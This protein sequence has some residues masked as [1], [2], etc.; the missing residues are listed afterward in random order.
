[1]SNN[2]QVRSDSHLSTQY[3]HSNF[4][5]T[6]S[7]VWIQTADLTD[8]GLNK[9]REYFFWSDDYSLRNGL[10]SL[11]EMDR[12]GEEINREKLYSNLVVCNVNCR[13]VITDLIT[14]AKESIIIQ[15]E[16][17]SDPSIFALLSQKPDEVVWKDNGY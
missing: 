7:G 11:F 5:L 13:D 8:N 16:E 14:K 3:L 9:Y 12:N 1:M 4:I 17:L 15:G 2:V 10:R 6:S